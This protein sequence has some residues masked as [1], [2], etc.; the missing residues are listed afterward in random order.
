MKWQ[1]KP[2][3][4]GS[5]VAFDA[6]AKAIQQLRKAVSGVLV[7]KSAYVKKGFVREKDVPEVGKS[8]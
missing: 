3:L 5:G 2:S 6:C 7:D 4:S 1:P 8:F